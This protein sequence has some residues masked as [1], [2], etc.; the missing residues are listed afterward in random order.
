M[1][2]P[3]ILSTVVAREAMLKVKANDCGWLPKQPKV[4]NP[5]KDD[6]P[7]EPKVSETCRY[8]KLKK[9]PTA[10]DSC[11]VIAS[12]ADSTASST[13]SMSLN[14]HESRR[15]DVREE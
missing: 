9:S 6:C 1:Q 2:L 4:A 13:A 5:A 3:T 8:C 15:M 11:D 7:D 14:K 12:T 10:V